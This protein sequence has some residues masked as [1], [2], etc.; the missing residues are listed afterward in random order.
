LRGIRDPAKS[1]K[2]KEKA[3]MIAKKFNQKSIWDLKNGIDIPTGGTG[4]IK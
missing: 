4:K 1:D 2:N 3:I